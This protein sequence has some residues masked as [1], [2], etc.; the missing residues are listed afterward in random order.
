[1]QAANAYKAYIILYYHYTSLYVRMCS[2]LFKYYIF[3]SISINFLHFPIFRIY[4]L[5]SLAGVMS[6]MRAIITIFGYQV[7]LACHAASHPKTRVWRIQVQ[8]PQIHI[9]PCTSISAR[10]TVYYRRLSI[11]FTILR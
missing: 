7:A 11:Y 2:Y 1:M 6:L 10:K 8:T 5:G 4:P 9:K 3:S